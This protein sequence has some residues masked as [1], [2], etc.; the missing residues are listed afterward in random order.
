MNAETG[1]ET[2]STRRKAALKPILQVKLRLQR[3]SF[4]KPDL[5]SLRSTK[6]QYCLTKKIGDLNY[7]AS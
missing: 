4:S 6:K 7:D 2:A 1:N 5:R 3:I